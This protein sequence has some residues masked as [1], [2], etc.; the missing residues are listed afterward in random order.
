MI[1]IN[2]QGATEANKN[3]I[4]FKAPHQTNAASTFVNRYFGIISIINAN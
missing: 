2:N 3:A 4:M 1:V